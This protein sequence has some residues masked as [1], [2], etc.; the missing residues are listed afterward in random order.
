MKKEEQL[1]IIKLENL[2]D[3]FLN[4]LL[5]LT[6]I[7]DRKKRKELMKKAKKIADKI[8]EFRG[9]PK[10]KKFWD[11]EALAWVVKIPKHV[12]QFIKK[13]LMKRI[14]PGGI[15]LSLGSGSYAY[16]KES[17]LLDYSEKMLEMVVVKFK[18]KVVHD[19][20]KIPWPFKKNTFDSISAVFIINYLKNL[21]KVFKEAK[22]ILKPKGKL[23][24]VQSAKQLGEFYRTKE[25]KEYKPEEIKKI[26]E[27]MGF[28]TK[29]EEKKT[30]RTSL[31]FIEGRK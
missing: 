1:K 28:K 23:I 11:V 17:V 21:K 15:N 25:V 3:D 29:V 24:I 12:R 13:E 22:R 19:I 9:W 5:R 7:R 10:G 6:Y 26:L 20:Q 14:K 30:K 4:I 16:V 2:K 8:P 31:M 27:Q 18:K